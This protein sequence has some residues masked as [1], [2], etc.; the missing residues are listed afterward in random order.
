M[1][2][3][4]V[5]P[6]GEGPQT[7]AK[8]FD[9]EED[10]NEMLLKQQGQTVEKPVTITGLKKRKDQ[11]VPRHGCLGA[12]NAV[13]LL[14]PHG[15][16]AFGRLCRIDPNDRVWRVACRTARHGWTIRLRTHLRMIAGDECMLAHNNAIGYRMT[17]HAI[18]P[19]RYSNAGAQGFDV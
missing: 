13:N 1:A 15:H 7:A 11:G 18:K 3:A 2:A 10:V 8:T 4:A 19:E 6:V 16:R 9:D 17:S 5:R 14:R 12:R